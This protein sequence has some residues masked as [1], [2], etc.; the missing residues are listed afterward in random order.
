M[1]LNFEPI[2]LNKQDKYIKHFAECSQMPSDYSFVN[3]WGW[4]EEYG[5]S[6]AWK[7]GFVW[8]KQSIPETVFWA[9]VG[10][11]EAAPWD[12]WLQDYVTTPAM[13]VRIPENLRHLWEKALGDRILSEEA[14]DHWDY[15]YHVDELI[16]LRGNRFHKKKNL[17]NQFIKKYPFEFIP[18][19]RQAT[20]KAMAM[21]EDWCTWRDCESS[22]SLSAENRAIARILSSWEKLTTVTGAA[23]L[24]DKDMAAYTIAESL[25]DET[26]V[27]H[28]EKG[29]PNY[30]GVY[31]AINQIFLE[32]SGHDHNIVNREQDLGDE[33]LRKSKLSYHPFDFIKKYRMVF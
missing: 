29:N 18:L 2:H 15:L 31:Q 14:R 11:W 21:Q 13:F 16:A 26:L 5:L 28:F 24:V 33:G 17:L 19:D 3:L 25:T 12:S 8:I 4:A 9:P 6:W 30:K 7:D 20:S 22:D 23:I 10:K 32:R 27:I 1:T